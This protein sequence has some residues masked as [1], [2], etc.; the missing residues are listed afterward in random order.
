MQIIDVG[1][2]YWLCLIFREVR[3]FSDDDGRILLLSWY[4]S[5]IREEFLLEGATGRGGNQTHE[6]AAVICFLKP[7]GWLRRGPCGFV[8][9]VIPR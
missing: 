2:R 3:G 4:V 6:L 8:N 1:C 7:E 5:G 9:W